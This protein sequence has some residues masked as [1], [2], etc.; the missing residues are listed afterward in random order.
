MLHNME[1]PAGRKEPVGSGLFTSPGRAV[2]KSSRRG[3]GG[4]P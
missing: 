3:C 4:V 1:G 2:G